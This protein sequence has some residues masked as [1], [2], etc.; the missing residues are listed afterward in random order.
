MA[1]KSY[2]AK[3]LV[4][5]K[6]KLKET[7]LIVTLLSDEGQTIKAVAKGARKPTSP[8]SSRL[9][10]GN[11][12]DGLF[13]KG[14]GDLDIIQ[15]ARLA[16]SHEALHE[17]ILLATAI[18]PGLELLA[19][20]GQPDIAVDRVFSL[21]VKYLDLIEGVTPPTALALSVA[22]LL[23]ACAFLGYRPSFDMCVSCGNPI[24]VYDSTRFRYLSVSEGGVVCS[25]CER[26]LPG[27]VMVPALQVVWMHFL[28]KS[29]FEAVCKQSPDMAVS[30][31]ICTF[32]Q[33]WIQVH[34]GVKLRSLDF[35]LKSHLFDDSKVSGDTE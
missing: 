1:S 22:H 19:R 10:P 33:S 15:E 25:H 20:S 12:V 3:A 18:T 2:S 34:G 16:V 24:D 7:D 28:L 27:A 13:A 21:T 9:E 6:T 35:L 4:L 17:D 14:R 31:S 5:K 30:L 8:F 32:L 29:P 11:V 26:E 23:K